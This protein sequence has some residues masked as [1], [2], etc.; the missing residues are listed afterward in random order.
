MATALSV[1]DSDGLA[2]VSIRRVAGE[3]GA[4]AM[5]LYTHI[6][7]KEDLLD[8][9]VDEVA[10]ETYIEGG[11]PADWREAVTMIAR[12]EREVA[13]RHPWVVDLLDRRPRVGPNGLRHLEQS[14][15]AL[16]GLCLDPRSAWR[17]LAAVT[18]Y[19]AGYHTRDLSER[20][21]PQQGGFTEADRTAMLRPY[22][23]RMAD[24]G[25]FPNLAPLLTEG[26]SGDDDN[27]EHGL[28]W[29]LDGIAAEFAPR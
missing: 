25:E 9:M 8:L 14:L 6:D 11:L 24:S 4:R 15:A 2:A 22:F 12:R 26:L 1:A 17:I 19:C 16:R 23:Q 27:F 21:A 29:L 3:L 18:D 7:R 28:R 20:R 10:R 5:S 13:R